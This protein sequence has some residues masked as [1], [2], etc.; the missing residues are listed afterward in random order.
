MPDM[1]L[2]AWI[3]FAGVLGLV[4]GSFLNVVIL[5]TARAHGGM[6]VAT[7]SARVLELEAEEAPLAAG[8][9]ARTIAL[10]ALQASAV[11][12]RTIFRCSAGCCCAGAAAT[13]RRPFRSSIRW[14]NCSAA[15]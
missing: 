14:W 15:Y 12:A 10:P 9:R 5:A 6:A 8:H 7:G 13:A 3:A 1:P 4:V 11:G 2:V